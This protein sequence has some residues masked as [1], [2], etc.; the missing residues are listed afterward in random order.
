MGDY[1]AQD[2]ILCVLETDK[3]AVEVRSPSAGVL[4]EQLAKVQDTV[5][6]GAPLVKLKPGAAPAAA[7]AAAPAPAPAP[8]AEAAAP[9]P[10]PKAAAPAPAPAAA[11]PPKPA[12]KPAAA[13]AP[14]PAAPAPGSRAENRVAMSR[15]R[16]RIAQRLKES[17]NTAAMLTTFQEV[18]M[19]ALFELREKYKVRFL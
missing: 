1:V 17:Q 18:D 6:V 11:A 8:K 5:A 3:V 4:E 15:M 19:S 12:A 9:A 16:Q 14:K 13:A 2:D 7:A 10:A